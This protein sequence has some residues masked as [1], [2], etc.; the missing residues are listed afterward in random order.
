M[1]MKRIVI[2][3]L[4]AALSAGLAAQNL[5]PEVQVTNEYQ[6]RLNDV[7]KQGPEM[8]VPDSLLHFDYHFDYSVLDSPYKGSYEFSPYAITI[9]P[10]P[11]A[12]DGRKLY[13]R[14]GAGYVFRPEFEAVWAAVDRKRFALNV[15]GK[16][17]GFWGQYRYIVPSTFE[18]AKTMFNKGWDF[19]AG[20]GVDARFKLGKVNF[21]AEAGYEGVYAGHE[22]YHTDNAHSPYALLRF[23]LNPGRKLEWNGGI[24]YRYVND[25]L[26]GYTPIQD[27]E[28]TADLTVGARPRQDYRVLS[29]VNV[30]IN[31]YY[32]GFSLH[33]HVIY[34]LGVLD[35]D[36]GFRIGWAADKFSASPDIRASIH[37]LNDYLKVYAGAT[38][39]DHYTQYWDY[40]TRVHRYFGETY[41][42]PLPVREVADVFV[43]IDGHADAGFQYDLK[44]GYRW[45]KDAPFWAVSDTGLECLAFQ[46]CSMF[47]ADLAVSW[48]S[49]RFNLDGV[50]HLVKLPQGVPLEVFEPSLVTGTIKG[51]YNWR[52]RVYA[53]L[54]LDM[55][56]ARIAMVK[57]ME[58]KMPGYADLGVWGE[59]RM[60][61]RLGFWLKGTNL[62]N[63]DVRIS[64]L[65]SQAGPAVIVGVTF[66]L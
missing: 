14:A 9:T 15:F 61:N 54:S 8:V 21:R 65:Y 40:K 53:G 63:H 55:A 26:D 51:G 57:G 16:A 41:S 56:S 52:K 62:L 64:P 35:I 59:Y 22:L 37:L 27:H 18:L 66:N 13:L 5:N 43:G 32:W 31:S 1:S 49:E 38:G 39:K 3:I 20:G 33:P 24:S 48:A 58:R 29:D 12:Y 50:A 30:V 36:G 47:H 44:A 45:V 46:D 11:R 23:S 19:S 2:S 34:Q 17:N 25:A 6:T 7:A 28:V 4:A 60:N 10:E 42:S